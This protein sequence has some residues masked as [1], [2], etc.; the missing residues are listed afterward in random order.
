MK[1]GILKLIPAILFFLTLP[2]L[3]SAAEYANLEHTAIIRQKSAEVIAEGTLQYLKSFGG[4]PM[5]IWVFFT[6]K[7]VTDNVQFQKAA[8]KAWINDHAVKRR[9]NVGID[10][11]VF[12]D[13]PL[14]QDYVSRIEA[15]GA[16]LRRESKWLN[17]ASFEVTEDLIATIAD[18]PF[19]Y[20]IKPVAKSYRKDDIIDAN[21]GSVD[22][23][24]HDSF[25][26]STA[27]VL[28]Y[29][30]SFD[31]LEMLNVPAMHNM[32][33]NGQ[34]VIVAML[35]TGY[36]KS[37]QAFALSYFDGRVLDEYDFINNDDNVQ[38]EAGDDLTQHNH[39]TYTWSTLGG[40][41]EGSLIGPAYGAMFLLA[42]TEDVTSESPVEEDNWVAALEWADSLGAQVISSSLAYPDW[43]DYSDMDG[44]TA[45]ITLA[46]NT[47]A[48]LGIVVCNAMGNYGPGTGTL[49][50]PADAFDIISVGAVDIHETVPGFSSSGPTFD[51]RTK[52]EVCA[53][54]VSTFCALGE[55]DVFYGTKNGT[56]LSTPLIGGAAAVLIQARPNLTPLQIRQAL[57]ETADRAEN[58]DNLYGW[59]IIDLVAASE[60][61][62]D[63]SADTTFGFDNLTVTFSDESPIAAN[64][65]KWYF[66]DGDSSDV[67]NPVHTYTAT[68]S[69]DV[70]LETQTADGPLTKTRAKLVNIVAD[71]I[72][73]V[74]DS[75]YPGDTGTVSIY[76]T[77][78]QPLKEIVV[79]ISYAG[80][81]DVTITSIERGARTDY[82]ADFQLTGEMPTLKKFAIRMVSCPVDSLPMLAPGTGEI[83]KI[84]FRVD[85]LALSGQVVPFDT[86]AVPLLPLNVKNSDVSFA[87]AFRTGG[88]KIRHMLRGDADFN[89]VVDVLDMIY[90][91]GYKFK[92]GTAPQYVQLGDADGNLTIDI[93]DILYLINFKFKGGPAPVQP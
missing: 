92:G 18:L 54:G 72:W 24:L 60:W 91:I 84:H 8:E 40:F 86:V 45:T 46:A 64:S 82:F 48:G 28:D 7:G 81:Y 57:I 67:Q 15:T 49:A 58:P 4:G 75:L 12:A 41:K 29:G 38:N 76:M 44:N 74:A 85:S 52:P 90:L 73:T 51:G 89:G 93:L 78:T 20:K 19:V 37:H 79:P 10:N 70:V 33:Y 62:A 11:P 21:L 13:L 61:G 59:G 16:K 5:H 42:K 27:D 65:W 66:G 77:N 43:Y 6:D 34:G 50:A 32:G 17:A 23:T 56:S 80:D 25:E 14:D 9:H 87:P 36:R 2:S 69:Y 47:A 3:M 1:T 39:G 30:P 68:G 55:S 63:F 26:K 22:N 35:D 71:T 88:M 31:Q 83:G 53:L